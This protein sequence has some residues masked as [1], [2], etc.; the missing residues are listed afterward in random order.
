MIMPHAVAPHLA[1][2]PG[3]IL[4]RTRISPL[5]GR[6]ANFRIIHHETVELLADRGVLLVGIDTPSI[7]QKTSRTIDAQLAA[8]RA[9]MR[10]LEGLLLTG[11]SAGDY[12]L[13]ALPLSFLD[14]DASPVRAI[15]RDLV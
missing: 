5:V 6:D 2:A 1:C 7:D 12:E 8:R 10:V 13:I 15:L 4:F 3:R 9:N 11:V 14:P